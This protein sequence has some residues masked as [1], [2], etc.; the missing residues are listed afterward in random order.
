M[1]VT[2]VSGDMPAQVKAAVAEGSHH[3]FRNG[4]DTSVLTAGALCAVGALL[5]V[6]GVRRAPDAARH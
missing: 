5:A 6:V 1:G 4:V 3:A 2:P